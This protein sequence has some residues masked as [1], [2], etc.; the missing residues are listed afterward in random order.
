L[1]ERVAQGGFAVVDVGDYGDVADVVGG[2]H[3]LADLLDCELYHFV[4]EDIIFG[5]W[6]VFLVMKDLK[7]FVAVWK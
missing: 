3:Y 7:G 1:Y 5:E 4:T 6:N 2:V